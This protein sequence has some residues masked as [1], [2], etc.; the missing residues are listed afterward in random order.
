MKVTKLNE[1]WEFTLLDHINL[2]YYLAAFGNEFKGP[3]LKIVALY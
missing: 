2:L 1:F 3:H